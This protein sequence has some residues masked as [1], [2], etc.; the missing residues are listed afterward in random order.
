MKEEVIELS[1]EETQALRAKLGL[2]PLR[3]DDD[4]V[5]R[6]NNSNSD[7][8]RNDNNDT[9][10]GN[11]NEISLS[12]EET[13]ALRLKLGLSPLQLDNI[14][15][16]NN[17][18]SGSTSN[19][20]EAIHRPPPI[21]KHTLQ[22]AADRI[23]DA[24]DKRDALDKLNKWKQEEK[25]EK[26]E[27]SA[28]DF[29]AKL[30]KGATNGDGKKKK[31]KKSV[32][33]APMSIPNDQEEEDAN[34][35]T[36]TDLQ[37]LKVGH[38][39][40]SFQTGT[41]TILTLSDKQ[42]LAIDADS[43]KVTGLQEA[44]EQNELINV[45]MM[46]D[47]NAL[48]NLKRKRL[49]ELGAGRAGGYAGF[50]DD[51][52]EEFGGVV[53][54]EGNV[55]GGGLGSAGGSNGK[56]DGSGAPKGFA[57]GQDGKAIIS[58]STNQGSDL[59]TGFKGG[60]ISLESRH[61]NKT[62]A[63]DFITEEEMNEGKEEK[64]EK[65]RKRQ[66]KLL[67]KMRKK[68]KKK[69]KKSRKMSKRSSYDE[70]ESEGETGDNHESSEVAVSDNGS[71][72]LLESLE[73]TA[74]KQELRKKRRREGSAMAHD[75]AAPNNDA[76]IAAK[77]E[78]PSDEQLMKEKRSKF[79]R[80]MEKGKIRTDKAFKS[81]MSSVSSRS[82]DTASQD[83]AF[84][85]DDDDDAFLNAALAKARRI[86]R[87]KELNDSKSSGQV[88][89]DAKGEAA[90]LQAIEKMKK[91]EATVAGGTEKSTGGITFENDE[92]QEFTRALR[93]REEQM[94]RAPEKNRGV[95][96]VSRGGDALSLRRKEETTDSP[97][98]EGEAVVEDV[99]MDELA[100]EMEH[101]DD[102]N[103]ANDDN[104]Q[105]GFGSTANSAPIG[106][107]MSNFLALLK[108]T[109]EIKHSGREEMRGRAKDKRTYEDYDH[110]D[111]KEVVKIDTRYA[112]DKDIELANRE[113]KLE[114]RDDYGRLLTR[115]EAYRNM[116]YQFHGHGS[117][118]KN[119][120]RRLKQ[121]E[122]EREEVKVAS[123]QDG[124]VGTLGAL[125]AT[126]KATGKAFIIHKT[127]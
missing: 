91:D 88:K 95:K 23:Q 6:E 123:R 47:T 74:V 36:A 62:I 17:S 124:G 98:K 46:D 106:R 92:I 89:T 26:E 5:P 34:E 18:S 85:G 114:Y 57:I 39:A 50:D 44:G 112:Q 97:S 13:N 22:Q 48:E 25:G 120:E 8:K 59:F 19:K 24:K 31:K 90:V 53:G 67:E 118:K 49:I 9:T 61:G 33:T 100:I 64:I 10:A 110:L 115:K 79:D 20:K 102:D 66:M 117:S 104:E 37:G 51:E 45:N 75:E 11:D 7:I 122:R 82:V 38:A 63:S 14:N 111:L 41:T 29:A 125:K 71:G 121:I 1:I 108:Q 55:L 94:K 65:E 35:Y 30:R 54:Y 16:N 2:A 3:L 83:G 101:E 69:M 105:G 42:I 77:P 119:Q 32:A 84:E 99:D 73:A 43:Q 15:N 107:G 68:D 86:Q 76:S 56:G 81:T 113:I 78:E 116:C 52:F 4:E 60:A 40:S 87:L 28:M 93:A 21:D 109:G 103:A 27:E 127:S 70:D 126:Q 12:V 72:S 80:I 96:A 58:Q